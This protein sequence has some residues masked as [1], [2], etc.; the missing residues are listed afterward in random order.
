MTLGVDLI[1]RINAGEFV[2]VPSEQVEKSRA[3]ICSALEELLD[4]GARVRPLYIGDKVEG[5]VRGVHL[6]ERKMLERWVHS[7][8]EQVIERLLLGTSLTREQLEEC[9]GPELRSLV[10]LVNEMS[11]S[12]IRLF[13][14]LSAFVSTSTSEQMWFSRGREITEHRRRE[15]DL[16]GGYAMRVQAAPDH[17]RLWATLCH[18]REVAKSRL[19]ASMNTLM[20]VRPWVGRSADG[21][22]NDLRN[23]ARRLITDNLEPWQEVVRAEKD[24][25]LDDGWAHGGDESVESLQRELKGMMSNDRH[26]QLID[27][28][29]SQQR[30]QA[31]K[32]QQEIEEK[33]A[34]R[35]GA[36]F[37]ETRITPMTE[38]EFQQVRQSLKKERPVIQQQDFEV[39]SSPVER[40]AKYR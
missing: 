36:G 15:V 31:E 17:A 18:Y 4:I 32:R 27:K 11:G 34:A 39:E 7:P 16:P 12:D 9:T 37:I 35:G 20:I 8:Q 29:E 25:Q 22:A 10:R 33:I 26:E 14:Y 19:D 13:P 24:T 30:E 2:K 38:K 40:L 3:N 21:M 5:W 1:N 23:T 28:F 6:G